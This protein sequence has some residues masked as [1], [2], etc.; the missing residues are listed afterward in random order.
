MVD[1]PGQD[2]ETFLM[3]VNL[4]GCGRTFLLNDSH[5]GK[6][7]HL[8]EQWSSK[9]ACMKTGPCKGHPVL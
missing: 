7:T 4:L 3:I 6:C 8:A 2:L 5:V 1:S 9:L